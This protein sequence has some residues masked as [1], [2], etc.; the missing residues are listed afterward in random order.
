M[1]TN[2]IADIFEVVLIDSNGDVFATTTLQEGNID[3]SVQESDVRG[4]RSNQLI[5]VLHSDRDINISLTDVEFKYDWLAKQLG[6]DIVTGENIAYKMPKWYSVTDIDEATTGDQPGI[7]LDETPVAT[8]SGLVIYTDEDASGQKITGY[9]VSGNVVDLSAATPAVAVGDKVYVKTYRYN[10]N[11]Q[12]QTINIDNA[13]FPNGVK[14]VLETLEIDENETARYK[15]Q[16]QF[17]SCLPTGNFTINTS[18]AREA[19]TQE[20]GLRVVKPGNST[21]VGK[22]LRIP[23]Q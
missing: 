4:G 17:D 7:I 9:T 5:T 18:S 15:V 14:A 3:F 23:L 8:D 22:C 19:S 12:T 13:I 6:Q 1:P 2:L 21:V 10:T 11:A 16:Y 20:F